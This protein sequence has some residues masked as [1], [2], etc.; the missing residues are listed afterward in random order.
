MSLAKLAEA[1]GKSNEPVSLELPEAYFDNATGRFWTRDA[2][3]RLSPHNQGIMELKLKRSGY[4]DPKEPLLEIQENFNADFAGRLAGWPMGYYVG[5]HQKKILITNDSPLIESG[6]W[7]L[8]NPAFQFVERLLGE[9][10]A[11][12]LHGW[13]LGA[14]NSRKAAWE[15]LKQGKFPNFKPGVAL[16]IVG[17]PNLGKTTLAKLL[18]RLIGGQRSVAGHPYQ[19]NQGQ[20]TFNEDLAESEIWLMDDEGGTDNHADRNKMK[21][22]IKQSVASTDMRVHPKGRKAESFECFHRT[23]IMVNDRLADVRVLPPLTEGF[24]DKI[25]ILKAQGTGFNPKDKLPHATYLDTLLAA[26]PGYLAGLEQWSNPAV[27]DDRFDV[28]GWQHEDVARDLSKLDPETELL[29]MLESVGVE[30]RKY[31]AANAI[32]SWTSG[33][34]FRWLME[35][36]P[37]FIQPIARSASHFGRLLSELAERE[38]TKV[39]DTERRKRTGAAFYQFNLT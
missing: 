38:P 32:E 3:G 19:M 14:V 23:I 1:H 11:D 18:I 34:L 15:R 12:R 28:R 35:Q 5:L 2:S 31:E 37:K 39:V 4:K 24:E 21:A 30:L 6:E 33:D 36:H 16:A 17:G 10:Q 27:T 22:A 20:T 8:D 9:E 25:L 29:G 13:I 26:C 7:N